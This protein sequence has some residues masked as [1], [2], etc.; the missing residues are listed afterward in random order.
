MTKEELIKG[1]DDIDDKTEIFVSIIHELRP[2][3]AP[4]LIEIDFAAD[5]F[6]NITVPKEF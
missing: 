4:S 2:E 3:E 1:L 6:I 5:R